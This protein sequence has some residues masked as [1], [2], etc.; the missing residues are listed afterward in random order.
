MS[1]DLQNLSQAKL[2]FLNS[3]PIPISVSQNS[4]LFAMSI[5]GLRLS[6]I[7]RDLSSAQFLAVFRGTFGTSYSTAL[8]GLDHGHKEY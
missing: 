4:I 6:T 2:E 7:H 8:R 5:V 1:I 3:K